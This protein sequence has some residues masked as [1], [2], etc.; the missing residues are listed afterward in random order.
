M[1]QA[2]ALDL[3]QDLSAGDARKADATPASAPSRFL[4]GVLTPVVQP[5][6]VLL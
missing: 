2:E 5:L 3:L 6:P 4:L 1:L